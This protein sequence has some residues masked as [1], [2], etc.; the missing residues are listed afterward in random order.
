MLQRADQR[1]SS[2][3]SP[4]VGAQVLHRAAQR[5]S[6]SDG[7][8]PAHLRWAVDS[9]S[10]RPLTTLYRQPVLALR[11]DGT[12]RRAFRW[13]LPHTISHGSRCR[14]WGRRAMGDHRAR[15][16]CLDLGAG[17]RGDGSRLVAA[18][19]R[20]RHPRPTSG[21]DRSAATVLRGLGIG[22]A[23]QPAGQLVVLLGA[24]ARARTCS[25]C[26]RVRPSSR[27]SHGSIYD[28]AA[29]VSAIV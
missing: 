17:S 28:G 15:D 14:R 24:P 12:Y 27:W 26:Q 21:A 16:L 10:R 20:R 6:P 5:R 1:R 25:S 2:S 8:R 3:S 29:S 7:V 23:G 19:R 18:R 9:G 22:S 4:N 13:C 11:T